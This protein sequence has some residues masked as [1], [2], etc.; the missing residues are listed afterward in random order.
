M[1]VERVVTLP[2]T[3]E[4][5]WGVLVEWERQA[6]WMLDAD[7]VTV[8]S[9]IREGVGVRLAVR[10]R[11]LGVPAFTEPM[12]VTGWDPPH[13]LAIRHGSWVVGAG[14]WALEAVDGGSRFTWSEDV[15]LRV[16]VVGSALAMLYRPVMRGLMGRAQ[17]ELRRSI[18]ARGPAR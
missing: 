16:P 14:A 9:Q 1:R 15:R 4:E 18:I 11:I 12:E 8:V 10:T 13:A 5:A 6:D 2:C 7:R 17:Q 3:V